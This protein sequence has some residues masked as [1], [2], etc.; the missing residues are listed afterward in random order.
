MKKQDKNSVTAA[1][2]VTPGQSLVLSIFPGIDLLGQGFELEGFC[3]VRGPDLIFGGDIRAFNAP[4]RV[5]AG[6]IGGPPCQ[7]F[8]SARRNEPTGTGVEMLLQY[9]RIVTE[10]KPKWYLLENV[11]RCPQITIDGYRSQRIDLRGWEF[12]LKQRRLRHFQFGYRVDPGI[13][14]PRT[15]T[16]PERIEAACMASEGKH[17]RRSFSEFCQAQG[18]DG[19]ISLPSFTRSA[20]Y[21]AVGNGVPL[22]MARALAAAIRDRRVTKEKLCICGCARPAIGNRRAATAACRKRLQ[23]RRQTELS[24]NKKPVH[25]DV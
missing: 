1:G 8:S 21:E 4:G 12:G 7:D 2:R 15:V 20:K 18:L 5:F 14:L 9:I 22:P 3:V 19:A 10:A 11:P 25:G 17:P 16:R 24:H 13:C 23:R 6:I